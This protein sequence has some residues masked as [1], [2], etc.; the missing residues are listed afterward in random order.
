MIEKVRRRFILYAMLALGLAMAIVVFSINTV[1][2]ITTENELRETLSFLSR[3]SGPPPRS[4]EKDWTKDSRRRRGILSESRYFTVIFNDEGSMEVV[5]EQMHD[6]AADD[7]ALL[8]IARSVTD[9]S[10]GV[11]HAGAYIYN[12]I[13][14]D[15]NPRL[16]VFLNCEMKYDSLHR[17]LF[18]SCII[19]LLCIGI[20]SLIMIPITGY[21][22]KPLT[23]NISRMHRFITNTSHE[24]KTP[25]TVI[26]ANMDVLSLD[27]P[28]NTWIHSTQKQVSQL[29][30]MVDEMVY[31]TRMEE[32][33]APLSLRRFQLETLMKDAAEPFAAMAEFNGGVIEQDFGEGV[34]VNADESSLQRVATILLDNAVK[35]APKGSTIHARCYLRGR[36]AVLETENLVSEPL[37]P[38]QCNR[39][40]DRFYRADESRDKHEHSGY[41][42]GLAIAS[43]V[44]EKHGG[45][46]EARM[47]GSSLIIRFMIPHA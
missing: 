13:F 2:F 46:M 42:I 30:R 22:V 32:K 16:M 31:L 3:F 34:F 12:C 1:V 33:D 26:S 37:T 45:Q 35:Y 14:K 11:H 5:V 15:G 28:D 41:G 39:L 23:E 47:N 6:D 43:A 9:T 40:F 17:M 25:L 44:A 27:Q 21:L 36:S 18:F 38:E 29:R 19:C 24:L 10:E 20:A 8:E 4:E 7:D